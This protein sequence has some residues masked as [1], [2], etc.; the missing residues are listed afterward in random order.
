LNDQFKEDEMGRVYSTNG[1]KWNTYRILVGK[2]DG[3]KPLGR[4]RCWSVDNI[5]MNLSEI[6]WDDMDWIDLARNKNQ[7]RALVNIAMN[8]RVP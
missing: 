7:L 5:K 8:L 6:G 3:K 4:P 2:P 1:E